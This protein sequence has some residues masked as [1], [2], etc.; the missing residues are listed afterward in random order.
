M[1]T[2]IIYLLHRK[3]A[4]RSIEEEAFICEMQ[5][6]YQEKKGG[7]LCRG[8]IVEAINHLYEMQIADFENGNIYL[9]ECVWGK[10][11]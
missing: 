10:A 2:Y 9:K 1:E 3:G 8:E 4:Y 5:K 6:W 7:K 11:K